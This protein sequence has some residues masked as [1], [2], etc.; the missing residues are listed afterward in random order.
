M[1]KI[2][3][4]SHH[5]ECFDLP[6]VGLGVTTIQGTVRYDVVVLFVSFV[7]EWLLPFVEVVLY[8]E[9]S[10]PARS[11]MRKKESFLAHSS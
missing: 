10:K 6:A 2:T 7:V 4:K 8:Q 3:H 5:K 1:M 11:S 9:Q